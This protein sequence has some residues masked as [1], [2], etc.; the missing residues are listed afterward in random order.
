MKF[1]S[2]FI[3]CRI[4]FFFFKIITKFLSSFL[5]IFTY[6]YF[7]GFLELCAFASG[8]PEV[9]KFIRLVKCASRFSMK[10]KKGNAFHSEKYL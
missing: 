3:L 6:S 9:K 1:G 7:F 5:C 8:R 10:E 2:H 4:S